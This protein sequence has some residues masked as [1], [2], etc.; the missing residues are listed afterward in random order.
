MGREMSNPRQGSCTKMKRAP[1]YLR[2]VP[3]AVLH[4]GYQDRPTAITSLSDSD[5]AGCEKLRKSTSAGVTLFCTHRVKIWATNEALI[6]F[7]SSEAEYYAAVKGPMS[8]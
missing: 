4:F 5:F 6:A 7:S 2:G 8:A 1:R 3:R